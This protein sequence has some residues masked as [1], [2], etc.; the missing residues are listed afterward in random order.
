MGRGAGEPPEAAWSKLGPYGYILQIMSP[1]SRQSFLERLAAQWNAAK[2]QR[3]PTLLSRMS[4]RAQAALAK[5]KADLSELQDYATSQGV[6]QAELQ[7]KLEADAQRGPSVTTFLP[8]Q[9][10]YVSHL[11]ELAAL[12]KQEDVRVQREMLSFSVSGTATLKSNVVK[13]VKL[14]RLITEMEQEHSIQASWK[15]GEDKFEEG[16]KLLCD[17]QISNA[18]KQA[19]KL[20]QEHLLLED[21]LKKTY[22]R[23]AETKKLLQKKD[24]QRKKVKAALEYWSNWAGLLRSL[25]CYTGSRSA[26]L[27]ITEQVA[28][29][30]CKGDL[31]WEDHTNAGRDAGE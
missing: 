22:S 15:S 2:Q 10:R 5:A 28:S 25:A 19:A 17:F 20:V 23:R 30:A 3:L 31:P 7:E 11:L 29:N 4:Q 1:A 27:K 18:Q 26:C 21:L 16:L 13:K 9:A 14:A 24:N 12:Q 6:S 8:W